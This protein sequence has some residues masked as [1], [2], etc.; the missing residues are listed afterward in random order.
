MATRLGVVSFLNSKPLI[1]GLADRS[2]VALTFDVPARLPQLLSTG[3]VDAALVPIIDVLRSRGDW[4]PVSDACI[5]CD[6]ETMT[7]RVFSQVPPDRITTLHVDGD[8]HTSVALAT[9]L[10]HELYGRAIERVPLHDPATAEA[11]LLIGDKVVDPA[12]GSFAYEVDLG[13]AW[14]QLTGLPFVFAVWATPTPDAGLAELLT[15]A[16][17]R[18]LAELEPIIAEHAPLHGWSSEAARRYLG[19]CLRFR[20]ESRA[21]AGANR[22]A[23]LCRQYDLIPAA[24]E[25][26]WT[27]VTPQPVHR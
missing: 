14:R 3:A 13:G 1:A 19:R 12:R 17:N 15:I 10:W 26:D 4:R 16:R 25:L 27:A 24:A 9:V 18:G 20:L 5:A 8:S 11:I 6:G 23:E 21:I 22:F 7:V 2:D